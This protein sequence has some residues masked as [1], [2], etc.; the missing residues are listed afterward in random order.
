[1]TRI[2]VGQQTVKVSIAQQPGQSSD[3]LAR[4]VTDR[5]KREGAVASRGAL[6][7]R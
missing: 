7:D 6:A 3:E 5:I 4:L 1:M 2:G